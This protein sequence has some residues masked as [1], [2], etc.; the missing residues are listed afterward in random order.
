MAQHD[1]AQVRCCPHRPA[2]SAGLPDS[3]VA[4]AARQNSRSA[5]LC[6]LGPKDRTT[7]AFQ[8]WGRRRR[9]VDFGTDGAGLRQASARRILR[10]C[11]CYRHDDQRGGSCWT[12]V[13]RPRDWRQC[14]I[15]SGA[16]G[17]AR[18][19]LVRLVSALVVRQCRYACP[20]LHHLRRRARTHLI[21]R[22]VVCF[23]L[24]VG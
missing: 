10:P 18:H 15:D 13:D 3:L 16:E 5:P 23:E 14:R 2:T 11:D 7:A 24:A 22:V 6:R 8:P 12:S 9:C 21:S 19:L 20:A 1:P 4:I 17:V